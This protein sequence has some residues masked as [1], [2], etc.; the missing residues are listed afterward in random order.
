MEVKR[1]HLT[2]FVEVMIT[3]T[4]LKKLSLGALEARHFLECVIKVDIPPVKSFYDIMKRKEDISSKPFEKLKFAR[5]SD[6][7]LK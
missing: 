4:F 7:V 2:H 5:S 3:D 6:A 1:A